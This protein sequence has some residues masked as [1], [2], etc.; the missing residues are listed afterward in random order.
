MKAFHV[1]IVGKAFQKG[2]DKNCELEESTEQLL[3][4][5]F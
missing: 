2:I 4:S 5:G 1:E 3:Q